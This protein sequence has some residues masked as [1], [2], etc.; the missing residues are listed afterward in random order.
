[1]H[2]IGIYGMKDLT[3]LATKESEKVK[4]K[5]VEIEER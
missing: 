4:T 3:F 1:M 2:V 5:E